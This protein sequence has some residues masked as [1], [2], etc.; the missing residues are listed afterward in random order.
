[1]HDDQYK[2]L[3][4]FPRLVEDLLRGFV[5]GDWLDDVDFSTLDKLSAEFVSGEGRA[6]R[7]D[8]VWRVRSRGAWL[9][10]LV[11]LEFQSRDDPDMALRILEYTTLLY[12]ELARNG[13]LEPDG[14]RPPVLPVVLYNG[15]APWRAGARGGRADSRRSGPRWPRIS[16]RNATS[17]LTSGA[18]G[19]TMLPRAT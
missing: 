15:A 17:L 5:H 16:R 2:R 11:M 9:H 14:R 6:R 4:A 19:A 7:G 18:Y 12:Q 13:A 1:M 8:T 3:F 10:L